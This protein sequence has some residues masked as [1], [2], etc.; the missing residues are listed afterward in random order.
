MSGEEKVT[1]RFTV[2]KPIAIM[3]IIGAILAV[4]TAL[5]SFTGLN[6]RPAWGYEIEN[7][8]TTDETL[9][10]F[11]EQSQIYLDTI[12]EALE[13]QRGVASDMQQD[14]YML[15]IDMIDRQKWELRN[16]L[17]AQQSQ[18]KSYRS[19]SAAVPA[20]IQNAV[21]DTEAKINQLNK[22]RSRIERKMREHISQL[23][24]RKPLT[25]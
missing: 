22:E 7:S 17:A 19:N 11:D 24:Q 3:A 16:E 25:E 9:T 1:H 23:E 10:I 15:Q 14:L 13:E 20:W 8:I 12:T 6:F 18:G 4:V 21:A 5:N 2:K